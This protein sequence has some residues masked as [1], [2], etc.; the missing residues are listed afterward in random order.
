MVLEGQ[1]EDFRR[2]SITSGSKLDD[3]KSIF[4]D[5]SLDIPPLMLI[6]FCLSLVMIGVVFF[7]QARF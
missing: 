1:V 2:G 4:P 7:F 5:L 6:N 3:R